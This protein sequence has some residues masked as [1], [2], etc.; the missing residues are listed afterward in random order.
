MPKREARKRDGH[1]VA[2]D[3]VGV[4]PVLC[5][6]AGKVQYRSREDANKGIV[7]AGKPLDIYRCDFCKHLHLTSRRECEKPPLAL[8]R[9][10]GRAVS[11]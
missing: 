11:E 9:Y 7:R 5:E 10:P 3:N 1:R 6:V 8:R 2:R 4:E